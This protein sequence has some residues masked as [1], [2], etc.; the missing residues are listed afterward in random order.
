MNLTHIKNKSGGLSVWSLLF[1]MCWFGFFYSLI[2]STGEL[3]TTSSVCVR[4]WS[5]VCYL[6]MNS[7]FSVSSLQPETPASCDS[8]H[9]VWRMNEISE[10][11]VFL[12]YGVLIVVFSRCDCETH[13]HTHTHIYF[14]STLSVLFPQQL[15]FMNE[16]HVNNDLYNR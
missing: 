14:K 4:V 7:M 3:N 16:Q 6:E 13:T 12:C 10:W 1:S 8:I 11:S 15:L 9:A 5:C 2:Y